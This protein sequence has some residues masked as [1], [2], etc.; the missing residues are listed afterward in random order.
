M[1]AEAPEF[2]DFLPLRREV[3]S[4]IA[5]HEG[6]WSPEKRAHSWTGFDRGFSQALGRKGWIG[7]T[8]PRELGGQGRS[9]VERYVVL[10]ELLAAGAPCGSH[11]IAD[12]QSG[13][14]LIRHGNAR[15]KRLLPDIAAGNLSFCIG[16]SEPD[17][18]SDLAGIRS[19]ATKYG[20]GWR[21]NGRKI[22][23]TNAHR[24]EWMIGTFRSGADSSRHAGLSQFLI[25]LDAP[26]ISIRPIDD[27]S[28]E[29]DFNEVV[30]DDVFVPGDMLVGAEGDGWKQ[31]TSE[32]TLERSGPER[33]LS[34]FPLVAAAAAAMREQQPATDD[35]VAIETLGRLVSNHI[36]LRVMS[37]SVAKEIGCGEEPNLEAAI[38]KDLG[39][40][41]EQEVPD[42][43]RDILHALPPSPASEY[44]QRMVAYGTQAAPSY[45]L[46]G[47]TR[48]I[49]RG[50]IA[51]E[52]GVR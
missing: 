34:S 46:R 45:S 39:N 17:A 24:S 22:W 37:R 44:A 32:L 40:S 18:G 28:G 20:T 14:L 15:Q 12:R 48:E 31:V 10:E 11:W 33:F 50:V 25:Q 27:L 47:G 2:E 5:A 7:M 26:G 13:P 23:T 38:I 35:A 43:V 21:L 9:S 41:L 51:R 52:L 29:T 30:F 42:A 8:W 19:R 49:I 3:R 36:I 16:M 6:A 4:F 1:G